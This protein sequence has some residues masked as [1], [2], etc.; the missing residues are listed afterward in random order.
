[1]HE[2]HQALQRIGVIC[3]VEAHVVEVD[4]PVRQHHLEELDLEHSFIIWEHVVC[5]WKLGHKLVQW[6]TLTVY[7]KGFLAFASMFF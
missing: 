1:M 6:R 5:S 3:D 7:L 4:L 2:T